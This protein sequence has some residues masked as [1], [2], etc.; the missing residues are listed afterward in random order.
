M[1]DFLQSKHQIEKGRGNKTEQDTVYIK[2]YLLS[3]SANYLNRFPLK[4]ET[5]C[6]V[7]GK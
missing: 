6:K 3:Q 7:L 1:L 4:L 5:I 2:T